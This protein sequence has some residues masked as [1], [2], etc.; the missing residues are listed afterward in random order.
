[1]PAYALR[2]I[3]VGQ[4]VTW[5]TAVILTARIMGVTDFTFGI[6]Q[7]K[8]QTQKVGSIAPS[9][10][11]ALGSEQATVHL[12]MDLSYEDI[13]YPLGGLDTPVDSG[14]PS[15]YTHNYVLP[16]FTVGAFTP[17]TFLLD[18][19]DD[20]AEWKVQGAM[21]TGITISGEATD[22]WKCSQDYIAQKI[23][24]ATGTAA[25]A[26]RTVELIRMADTILYSDLEGGTIGT[27]AL[28]N[29]MVSFNLDITSGRHLKFFAGSVYPTATGIDIFSGVLTLRLELNTAVKALI[30]ASLAGEVRR[31]FRIKA[32]SGTHYVQLDFSGALRSDPLTLLQ[33]RDGN[34]VVE[35]VFDGIYNTT[36]ALW[37]ES[38]AVNA[39][40]ALV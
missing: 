36:A 24:E 26:E 13:M 14:A 21:A 38:K 27:T 9:Q 10:L 34:S 17:Y 20:A 16:V 12:E 3:Y 5:G 4:E 11:S 15:L 29:S 23:T 7:Q 6:A 39:V 28:T 35:L 1:M 18:Q 33:S 8:R 25:P 31:Q 2:R 30:T 32:L 22:I 40:P 37:F 19:G